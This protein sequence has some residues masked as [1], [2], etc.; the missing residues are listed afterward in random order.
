MGNITLPGSGKEELCTGM[1]IFL[2]QKDT[3]PGQGSLY[4]TKQPGRTRTD[5]HDIVLLHAIF[6]RIQGGIFV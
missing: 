4:R 5:Y 2:Q 3:T 6:K 1:R